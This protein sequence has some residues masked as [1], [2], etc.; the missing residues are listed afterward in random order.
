MKNILV[1]SVNWLGDTV[2]SAPVYKNLKDNFPG[3]RITA[4]AV[5]RVK[6]ILSL[7]PY[8]DEVIV[9]DEEGADRP[10]PDKLRLVLMLRERK[11]DI[12]FFL[13][14]SFS[15]A[16]LTFCAGIPVRAGFKTRNLLRVI[17]RPVSDAGLD[18]M[19]RSDAYLMLLERSGITVGD[20]SCSL[21]LKN[22]SLE[23][24]A[25]LL[26]S[27]GI[28]SDEPLCV[29]NT[30][31]N[32]GLKQWPEERFAELARRISREK[33]MRVVLTGGEGDIDRVA[34]IAALSGVKPVE[35]AGVT[36]L[37]GTA[38]VFCRS[39]VVISADSGPLHL[40]SALGVRV[41]AIFGPTRPEI[42]GPRGRGES[43]V[44]RKDVGCNKAPCY[45]LECPD[46]RC[47]KAVEV[48]DVI[49]VL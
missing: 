12:V 30:G 10:L 29:L 19:H 22:E 13:R 32:W 34:R 40:A 20:R 25:R 44:V 16:W 11:F 35:L 47:M 42:T 15:R 43:V 38:A 5:P 21:E 41:V 9:Y 26:F 6:P 8:V 18:R 14:P 27:R 17:N 39:R 46:N 33:H 45:Y 24:A 23:L 36:D 48:D 31:G 7:C 28:H 4:L 2:F 1:F 37:E 49:Q 3:A